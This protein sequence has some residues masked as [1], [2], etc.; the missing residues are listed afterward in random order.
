MVEAAGIEP[1]SKEEDLKK[2]TCLVS[3]L[4][5]DEETPTDRFFPTHAYRVSPFPYRCL[6]RLSRLNDARSGLKAGAKPG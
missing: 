3:D 5:S 6:E 4:I 2:P 1:A